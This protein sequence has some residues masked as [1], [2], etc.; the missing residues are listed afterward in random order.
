MNTHHLRM[1]IVLGIDDLEVL[2]D[3]EVIKQLDIRDLYTVQEICFD[4]RIG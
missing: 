2:I 4:F 3:V 1:A